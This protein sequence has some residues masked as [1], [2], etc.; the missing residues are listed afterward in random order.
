MH[1]LSSYSLASASKIYKP[2]I[3]ESYIQ[4]PETKYITFQGS[5]KFSSKDYS[6]WQT[7]ISLI[8]PILQKNNIKIVQFGTEKERVY[9]HCI[10][11]VGKTT[12]GQLAYLIKNSS[13]HFGSDSL[14]VH[15]SSAYDIPLVGLYSIIQAKNAGPYFGD[16]NK[17]II[18]ESFLR[19]GNKK[20]S[21]SPQEQPKSIDLIKPEEI[22]NA[23]LKLLGIDFVFPF[24]T[25][26]IGKQY[27]NLHDRILDII[28]SEK[29]ANFGNP[30]IGA[31][32][33]MDI[34]FDEKSLVQQ[35]Q[36]CKGVI[37]TNKPINLEILK[38]FRQ[39][40]HS[41]A[42]QIDENDYPKFAESVRKLG[43]PIVLVSYLPDVQINDKKI[44]YYEL[45]K[46]N[47]I[48]EEPLDKIKEIR[49]NVENL[50]YMSNKTIIH[51]DKSYASNS[52]RIHNIPYSEFEMQKAINSEEFFK[53]L[54]FFWIVKKI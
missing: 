24:E 42:Y 40:I 30:E 36:F 34:N 48:F 50:H 32:I 9:P 13:L 14:G 31:E 44:N 28:P 12:F 37:I 33:R 2:F 27:S 46:I 5:T 10:N 3:Y 38:A 11:Y 51:G 25:F 16:K 23:I 4:L 15:L 20:P 8:Y 52:A 53:E 6:Y 17:Q 19:S 47:K 26:F 54:N 18:F 29:V 41:V 1:L 49:D 45:G 35:L 43:I 21:Y 22:A 7:V 39:K